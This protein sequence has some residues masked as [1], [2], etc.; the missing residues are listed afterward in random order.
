MPQYLDDDAR[1]ASPDGDG[2]RFLDSTASW[3]VPEVGSEPGGQVDLNSLSWGQLAAFSADCGK[4]GIPGYVK[5]LGLTKDVTV[6]GVG[7]VKAR[8]IGLN[9]DAYAAGGTAGFTFQ[10]TD[11]LSS[12]SPVSFTMN[13]NAVG[14]A[15]SLMRTT[16]LP[17][18][19]AALPADL[20]AVMKR[21]TKKTSTANSGTAVSDTEDDLFLLSF[22]ESIGTDKTNY[23]D[24]PIASGNYLSL[25]GTQYEW[26]KEHPT[27]ADHVIKNASGSAFNWWLR[28]IGLGSTTDFCY[29]DKYGGCSSSLSYYS[30]LPAV[31]FCI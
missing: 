26:Y 15:A 21:V 17:K 1:W 22:V 23:S 18:L 3:T 4:V 28:S 9:H 10:L 24:N 20:Q 30:C 13:G 31:G 14:W 25:E 12:S 8:L 2:R 16:N 11:G 27:K 5:F 19:R 29:M 7:T 6:T